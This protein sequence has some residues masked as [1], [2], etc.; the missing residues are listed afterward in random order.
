MTAGSG[1]V[2]TNIERAEALHVCFCRRLALIVLPF[3]GLHRRA[4]LFARPG[5]CARLG[6][7]GEL[8]A[9]GNVLPDQLQFMRQVGFDAFEVPDRFPESVWQKA[10]RS[11]SVTYQQVPGARNVWLARHAKPAATATTRTPGSSSLTRGDVPWHSMLSKPMP[12][13]RASR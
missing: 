5:R 11:M 12:D 9:G 4:R 2:F 1:V 3:P 6:F 13:L 10:A 7:A 8:R